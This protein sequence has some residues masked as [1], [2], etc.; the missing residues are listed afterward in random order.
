MWSMLE[1]R[2]LGALKRHPQ[3]SARL[4]A[5]EAEVRDGRLAPQ[6]AVDEISELM[7]LGS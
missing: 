6:K 3:A 4:P 7:G 2:L 5:L 1:E